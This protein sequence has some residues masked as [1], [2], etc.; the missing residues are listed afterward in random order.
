MIENTLWFEKY[1][2]KKIEDCIL[3]DNMKKT[4]KGFLKKKDVPNLMLTGSQGTG[5]TTLGK[6]IAKELDAE[7]LYID[8]STD[9]GKAMIQEM[10][11]PFASTV[12]I[13]NPEVPKF[14]LADE[15]LEENETV[16]IGTIDD[17]K[18][19]PLKDL[20]FGEEYPIVSF[21]LEKNILENDTGYLCVS[22]KDILYKVT[23]MDGRIIRC[24]SK[25]P[26]VILQDDGSYKNI[27]LCEE[28]L[29]NK[30][31]V[32]FSHNM[33]KYFMDIISIEREEQGVVMDVTVRKNHTFITSGGLV[34]HNCDYLSANAM[35]SLRPII[36]KYS[37]T[38]RFIFTGNYAERIIPALKSRCAC[39]DFSISKEEKPNLMM[40]F[41]KRC[42][43]ILKDN[44][45]EYDVKVLM[46][47]ISKVFP[48]FR[49][50]I[51]ELQSY[52]IGHG[53]I[54]E[55][56]LT[57]GLSNT[58]ADEVYPLLKEH[59]FDA[60]R[61]WVAES[62]NSPEDVFSSMYNR[63]NDYVSKESQPE[64]I[65]ILAQY[66]DFATRVANQNINLMACFTEMMKCL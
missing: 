39:F 21:N 55:G 1:R 2:P 54:D 45:I 15:C 43:Y 65:L 8:C 19:V 34:T 12:S 52:S 50:T 33:E 32:F 61:K 60:T 42:E 36:E 4:F 38:T 7:L 35:A 53:K 31:C 37:L 25:H 27:R 6:V 30:T 40:N 14:V 9:N 11:V 20:S 49:R 66:Q 44:N 23:F 28:N 3:T 56:I 46:T 57:L 22:K 41:F 26:F 58:I 24:N 51:N 17:Y 16:R 5:K 47:F 13:V 18:D 29:V 63:M 62:V 48:D 59:K 64:L 10:I